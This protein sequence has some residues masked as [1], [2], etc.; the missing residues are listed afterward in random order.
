MLPYLLLNREDSAHREH[1]LRLSAALL[2]GFRQ[3][4]G[5]NVLGPPTPEARVGLVSI[6]IE[7][8]DPQEAA[9]A[10]DAAHRIQVRPGLHCAPLMHRALRT[11]DSGGTI[12]FSL[13]QFNTAEDVSETIAAV[14]ELA[15]SSL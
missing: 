3:I 2:S 12:R 13:G 4:P 5:V 6:C 14:A 8:Y 1:D 15:A 11:L 7:G 9:A 10:L